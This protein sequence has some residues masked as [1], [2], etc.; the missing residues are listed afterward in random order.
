MLF[1]IL[2]FFFVFSVRSCAVLCSASAVCIYSSRR[3]SSSRSFF[4]QIFSLYLY[5]LLLLFFYFASPCP[6]TATARRCR[7]PP[8]PL[9][10]YVVRVSKD[11]FTCLLVRFSSRA[12]SQVDYS[13]GACEYNGCRAKIT[14]ILDVVEPVCRGMIEFGHPVGAAT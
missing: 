5:S 13:G 1:F 3:S 14:F 6:L 7:R 2:P 11:R 8:P 10:V 4:F 12:S 9:V